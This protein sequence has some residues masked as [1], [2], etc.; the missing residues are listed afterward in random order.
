MEGSHG[1]LPDRLSVENEKL[2]TSN[3]YRDEADAIVD[4]IISLIIFTMI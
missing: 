1:E 3:K 4:V 2:A